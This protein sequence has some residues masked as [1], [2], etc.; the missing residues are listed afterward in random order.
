MLVFNNKCGV[1]GGGGSEDFD[2]TSDLILT[3]VAYST[4]YELSVLIDS[5]GN[6]LTSDF[7]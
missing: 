3:G 5:D 7:L 2:T 1:S 4:N 6:V